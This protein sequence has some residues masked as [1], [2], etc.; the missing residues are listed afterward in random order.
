MDLLDRQDSSRHEIEK[1]YI[2]TITPYKRQKVSVG[3]ITPYNAQVDAIGKILGKKYSV[4]SD[5]SVSV[6]SVD[7]FQ[8]SEEDII[9]I[10]TARCNEKGQ[11]DFLSNRQRANVALT[12]S[13]YCLWILG[14][15]A[16]LLKNGSIWKKLVIDAKIRQCFYDY[17]DDQERSLSKAIVTSLRFMTMFECFNVSIVTSKDFHDDTSI[18]A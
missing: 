16:T 17:D 1:Q 7:G 14:N 4:N 11:I 12:R 15:E 18:R 8:G 5:F 2:M 3:V 6:C 10:S 13:R 9:I